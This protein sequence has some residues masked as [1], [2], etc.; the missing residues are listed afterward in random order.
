MSLTFDGVPLHIGPLASSG[1]STLLDGY[2]T[3][4]KIILVDENTYDCCLSYLIK[5]FP[6]LDQAEVVVLPTGEEHKSLEVCFQVWSTLLEYQCDKHDLLLVL[7]GGM[8]TDMGGFIATLYKRGMDF[9]FIPTTLLAM[10][11]ASMGGKNGVNVKEVKNSVGT[12]S[13][14]KAIFIDP[15]FLETLPEE[16]LF[17]G[18]AEMIK[19]ALIYDAR[20]WETLRGIDNE[21]DLITPENLR[22]SIEI[23]KTIV[24][25]DPK[26]KNLR[27]ILNFGHTIGHA[28]ESYSWEGTSLSHGHA[29]ALGIIAESFV[30]WKRKILA[31]GDFREI[32]RVILNAF[33]MVHF[34]EEAVNHIID[35]MLN[36]KKNANQSIRF[37]LLEAIGKASFDQSLRTK[38]VGEAM[39][40]LSLLAKTGN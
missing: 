5:S 13:A 18:F 9:V 35:L 32:E 11:D 21:L 40:Y 24:E 4:R 26:E 36:D 14:P 27:K 39:L 38:E 2:S 7:G 30:A 8:V 33:P 10:V 28:I 31:E 23:K 25:K 6:N 17:N 29:V 34:P 22:R 15:Q 16:E 12:F 37:V 1:L 19:H 3:N 20:Y